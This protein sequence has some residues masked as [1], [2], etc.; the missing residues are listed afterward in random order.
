MTVYATVDDY[1]ITIAPFETLKPS[2]Q[3][4]DALSSSSISTPWTASVS[5]LSP[6]AA[7]P[8]AFYD[9]PKDF[10]GVNDMRLDYESSIF[11]YT[12]VTASLAS[13]YYC[14]DKLKCDYV[15]PHFYIDKNSE[16]YLDPTHTRNFLNWQ[17][18]IIIIVINVFEDSKD[19]CYE[20]LWYFVIYYYI[21]HIF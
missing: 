15:I 1:V 13:Q 18:I 14:N 4:A 8:V 12:K 5:T 2:S 19:I 7:L 9:T 11:I 16:L 20:S 17:D 21:T 10:E 3:A 6:S